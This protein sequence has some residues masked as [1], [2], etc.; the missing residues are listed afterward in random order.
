MNMS[1]LADPIYDHGHYDIT[2]NEPRKCT[3]FSKMAPS[4][5]ADTTF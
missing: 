3:K 2:A 1:D 4:P 5:F